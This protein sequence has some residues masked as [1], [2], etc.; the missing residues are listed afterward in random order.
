MNTHGI[1]CHINMDVV[2][3]QNDLNLTRLSVTW[4]FLNLIY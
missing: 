3:T 1:D 4:I 2:L